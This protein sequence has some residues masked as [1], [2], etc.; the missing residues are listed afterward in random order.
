MLRPERSLR[1]LRS[2]RLVRVRV[3]GADYGWGVVCAVTRKLPPA[4][5]AA[6]PAQPAD[7][8][9]H[10]VVDTLLRVLPPLAPGSPPRGMPQQQPPSAA[11]A[12][13]AAIA[14]AAANALAAGAPAAG[15]GGL[16]FIVS[17]PPLSPGAVLQP[18]GSQ[19]G[20][21]Y[22]GAPA[23]GPGNMP[24]SPVRSA[25]GRLGG[26]GTTYDERER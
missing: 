15:A 3:A 9:S 18:P 23:L 10:Y 26:F 5:T 1:F 20:A 6:A 12:A 2:G 19:G 4:A 21:V 14:T 24:M 16:G 22:L 7:A 13:A 8:T 17:P 25:S 11:A